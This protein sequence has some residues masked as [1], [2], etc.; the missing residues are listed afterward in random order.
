MSD[1]G[2]RTSTGVKCGSSEKCVL[3]WIVIVSVGVFCKATMMTVGYRPCPPHGKTGESEKET[4][5][6]AGKLR[7]EQRDIEWRRS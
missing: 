1:I 3:R 7:Y 6:S 2:I 5:N 4:R